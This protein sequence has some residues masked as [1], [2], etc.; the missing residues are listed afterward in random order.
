MEWQAGYVMGAVLMP[1]SAVR[2]VLAAVLS[3][4]TSCDLPVDGSDFAHTLG[5]ITSTRFAVSTDAA[6]IRLLTL[7]LLQE[8]RCRAATRG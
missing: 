4:R 3:A 1:A 2:R 6:R 7:E 8:P 5:A